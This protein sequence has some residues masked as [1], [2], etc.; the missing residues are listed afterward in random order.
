MAALYA[1]GDGDPDPLWVAAYVLRSLARNHCFMDGNKRIAWVACL[2]V[3]AVAAGVTVEGDQESA[4]EFVEG[5]ATGAIVVEEVMDWLA[6]RLVP[7]G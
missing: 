2:E 5:V 6:A 4:A 1:H 3:L 7:L